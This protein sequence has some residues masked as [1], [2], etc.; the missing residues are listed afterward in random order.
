[1]SL[2][3]RFRLATQGALTPGN[4]TPVAVAPET[5]DEGAAHTALV[6][7][8]LA[9]LRRL[10]RWPWQRWGAPLGATMGLRPREI[11]L[12][13]RDALVSLEGRWFLHISPAAGHRRAEDRERWL[14]VPAALE[15]VGFVAFVQACP[16]GPLFPVLAQSR[17]PGN[18]LDQWVRQRAQGSP[19]PRL[20]ALTFKDLRRAY[21]RSIA[22]QPVHPYATA[23]LMGD[24]FTEHLAQ[25]RRD[26]A[27]WRDPARLLTVV[28]ALPL[29][30]IEGEVARPRAAPPARPGYRAITVAPDHPGTGPMP[31]EDTP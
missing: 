12:L 5:P 25:I 24:A 19:D 22:Q 3:I 31:P 21:K 23:A 13:E 10:D 30:A 8:L 7:A 4:G 27:A 29:P 20:R 2:S 9:H 15:A 11:A 14:P 17:V 6:E 28:D 26:F 1:M 16:P 18:P